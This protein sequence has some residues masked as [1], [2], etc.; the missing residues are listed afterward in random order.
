MERNKKIIYGG[1]LVF[2]IIVAAVLLGLNRDEAAV[3]SEIDNYKGVSVYCNGKDIENNFGSHYSSDGYYYGEKWQCVEFVKRFYYDAKRHRMP[4]VFGNA[5]DFFD[6]AVAQGKINHRRGMLQ[7]RNGGNVKPEVDDLLVFTGS[8]YGHV[9][10]ITSTSTAEVEIIQQNVEEPRQKVN[11]R[12]EN[13]HYYLGKT[14]PPA[15]WLRLE[16]K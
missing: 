3:S 13:G 16:S 7:Y 1:I 15:G 14:D 5:K 8:K 10:V 12:E 4:D 11:L 2:I 9:A 6:P